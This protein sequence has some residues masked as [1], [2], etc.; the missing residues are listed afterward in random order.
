[1]SQWFNRPGSNLAT[2][3][4]ETGARVV[5]VPGWTRRGHGGLGNHVGAIVCHHTAGPEPERTASN[6]PSLRVVRDGRTGLAGPLAQYGIGFD[7]TIYVIAAGLAWHA[8][9]GGWRGSRGNSQAIGIEAE[10]GGDGDWMPAQLDVYP[11]LCAAICQFLGVDAGAVCAHREWA[12]PRKIDPAGI[13]MPGFRQTVAGYL[14]RP[15][16]IRLGGSAPA[17]A[18]GGIESMALDTRWKDSYGNWQTVDGFMSETQRDLN[19]IHAAIYRLQQSRIPGD[20]NET[21]AANLWFDS[22]SW[23]AQT[24]G[25]VAALRNEVA[26]YRATV[27]KLAEL[28]G[29]QQGIDRDSIKSAVSE[30]IAENVVSVDVNVTGGDSA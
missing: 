28:L 8:G 3:A 16:T 20:D 27:D 2:I 25:H 18:P 22:G 17:A 26:G 12:G 5:E 23:S 10:D 4:R 14:A 7:G 19:E 15:H 9:S 24:L 21:N 29:S 6:Y 30:A 1:M 13:H 11:R